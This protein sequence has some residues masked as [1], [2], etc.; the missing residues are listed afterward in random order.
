M[1][2]DENTINAENMNIDSTLEQI[3]KELKHD[4]TLVL[5]VGDSNLEQTDAIY[6][7]LVMR[8]Y[9]VRKNFSRN[10]KQIIV[11]KKR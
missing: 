5:D 1:N 7:T 10:N 6:D 2:N 11:S 8:G 9:Q 3:S 4:E